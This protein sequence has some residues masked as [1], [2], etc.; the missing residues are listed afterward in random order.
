MD[1]PCEVDVGRAI[2]APV[3]GA[4]H[5]LELRETRLPI[6]QDVLGDAQ[7]LRQFADS[8]EGAGVFMCGKSF[9]DDVIG[10]DDFRW[11]RGRFEERTWPELAEW[12]PAFERLKVQGGWAGL[13]EVNTFDGNAILT[14]LPFRLVR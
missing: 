1:T 14:A 7:L 10:Y 3:A 13:Y 6:A 9:D 5:R 4:L 8:E 11:E 2:V 12:L